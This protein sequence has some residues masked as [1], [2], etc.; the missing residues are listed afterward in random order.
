MWRVKTRRW[1]QA[2]AGC[3]NKKLASTYECRTTE[4]PSELSELL[5][6]YIYWDSSQTAYCAASPGFKNFRFCQTVLIS[7]ICRYIKNLF[8]FFHNKYIVESSQFCDRT[9]I[10]SI[11]SLD[12]WWR[13]FLLWHQFAPLSSLSWPVMGP[14]DWGFWSDA[15]GQPISFHISSRCWWHWLWTCWQC[16]NKHSRSDKSLVNETIS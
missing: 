12:G 2:W 10:K 9:T 6:P 14:W 1:A 5:F 16:K 13:Y 8:H 11:S 15:F 4:W 3:R 7:I